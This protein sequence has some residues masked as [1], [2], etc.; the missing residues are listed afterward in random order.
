TSVNPDVETRQA[1]LRVLN[2]IAVR[3][4][5]KLNVHP[6]YSDL[7]EEEELVVAGPRVDHRGDF[8][9]GRIV[10]IDCRRG[11]GQHATGAQCEGTL[12]KVATKGSRDFDPFHWAC[13]SRQ[14]ASRISLRRLS[15]SVE[16]SSPPVP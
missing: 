15:V 7:L 3:L 13:T 6:A 2:H 14:F 1:L 9:V 5:R 4:Q 16:A 10:L 12:Q 11:P 8:G